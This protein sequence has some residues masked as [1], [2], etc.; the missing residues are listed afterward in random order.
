MSD[1][2]FKPISELDRHCEEYAHCQ[3]AY[4]AHEGYT[5]IAVSI[6]DIP[7]DAQAFMRLPHHDY[8]HAPCK[9]CGT[10][11]GDF[12]FDCDDCMPF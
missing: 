4:V 3:Y 8:G 12:N 7:S 9:S 6:D 5:N 1:F 10:P 11:A 2:E